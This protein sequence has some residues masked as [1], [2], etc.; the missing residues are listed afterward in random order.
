MKKFTTIVMTC[1]IVLVT[2]LTGCS[3]FRVDK[4]KYYNEILAK[5]GDEYIT[6]FDLINAY[7]S[8]G[9]TTY[10]VQQGLTEEQALRNTLDL[11]VKREMLTKYATDN[12]N[13][14]SLTEYEINKV[15]RDTIDSLIE[16]VA[17]NIE[18]ARKI[19]KVEDDS[20]PE[21][22][23]ETTEKFKLS[24]Y[25][26]EKRVTLVDVKEG[27]DMVKQIAYV[28]TNPE[29]NKE[30]IKP[31]LADKFIK[32]YKN[33]T[34]ENIVKALIAKF[35][36]ELREENENKVV[37]KAL[38]L[39]CNN[40]INY[41]Y[42]LRENGKRLS[43]NYNDLLY[44]FVER[45]FDSQLSNAYIT[46][47]NTVYLQN[48]VLSND[49]IINA[50]KAM[51]ES[52][53]A[54]YVNDP[55]AY[56]ENII[57]TDSDLIY[58]HPVT[59]GE[60]G[61][62][63]H[64]LL[65]F[66]NVEEDLTWLKDNWQAMDYSVAEYKARQNEYIN[67]IECVQRATSDILDDNEEILFEEGETLSSEYN[68]YFNKSVDGKL[69][70]IEEYEQTVKDLAS[71]KKFMFKYT[72]DNATLTADMPY[73]I[74]Y[75]TNEHTG[76]IEDGKVVGAYSSMVNNF[77]NEAIRL[78]KE[79]KTYTGSTEYI[80]TNYGVHYLYYVGPVVNTISIDDINKLTVEK[81]D[82]MVLN[83]ATGETYLDRVFDLVYPADSE[84]MFTTNT[85]YSSYESNLV[86]SLYAVYPVTL[87]ETKIKGSNK[88]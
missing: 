11:L 77:T 32:D 40:L 29:L 6:R 3:T 57:K 79:G 13:K 49:S 69:S 62:F 85:K 28:N 39:T 66:N 23:D 26:Y 88:I 22:N 81:L 60:F 7:N 1:L 43:T 4:V 80:L 73:I 41:E 45:T 36:Q 67:N 65:P 17:D 14:Y 58:Y 35:K 61:Y 59:D 20:T 55:D 63:L 27:A 16:S 5:V 54:K 18:T 48:E 21:Q 56:Y 84:G 52:D 74:G 47:V 42:Y 38:E 70:I 72:T 87:Y 83:E 24:E 75:N 64:V 44:R 51:Y 71:F 10:A 86:E 34:T 53:Y 31:V 2:V 33:Q 76:E 15:Y 9:Y 25:D 78:M 50:F 82:K 12:L 46:R 8:Y 37:D 19:Y 30:S 68:T